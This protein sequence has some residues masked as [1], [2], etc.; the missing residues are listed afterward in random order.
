MNVDAQKKQYRAFISDI[1]I[2][3]NIQ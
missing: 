3:G 2:T 1:K